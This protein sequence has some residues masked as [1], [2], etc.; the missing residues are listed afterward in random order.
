MQLASL[1]SPFHMPSVL[2]SRVM[3]P[4][5]TTQLVT[6]LALHPAEDGAR[7]RPHSLLAPAPCFPGTPAAPRTSTFSSP[8]SSFLILEGL[9]QAVTHLQLSPTSPPFSLSPPLVC[10]LLSSFSKFLKNI[11]HHIIER[12]SYVVT[13][14]IHN[15]K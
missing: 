4:R 1:S 8:P 9:A 14:L 3:A 15:R 12:I 2:S 11:T 7:C 10:M 6:V 5:A 13:L